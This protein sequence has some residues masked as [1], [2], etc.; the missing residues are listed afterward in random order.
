MGAAPITHAIAIV[1]AVQVPRPPPAERLREFYF[2]AA[3]RYTLGLI[4]YNMGEFRVG[5]VALIRFQPP[6]ATPT[7]W[8]FDLSGG[9]LVRG[10]AGS[11]EIGWRDGILRLDVSDYTPALP[12]PVYRLTQLLFH[13]FLTRLVLLQM[14]GRLPAMALPSP[15]FRR[16][17]GGALDVLVCLA[18][19]QGKPLRALPI[20]AV[21]HLAAWRLGGRT[22]GG[23]I[24][25]QRV[26]AVDGSALT[27]GQAL[28]RLVTLPV[29]L[30]RL[31]AVHDEIAGTDVVI[32][33]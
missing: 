24:M 3:Q 16:L 26:R 25:G 7:G 18:L 4:R 23:W 17:G 29:G 15:P 28:V 31:R 13:H 9:L 1:D 11:L 19:A 33:S 27:L 14:R 30:L 22:L 32:F 21:Y 20:A 12:R 2:A 8:R 10:G 6:V 5:P